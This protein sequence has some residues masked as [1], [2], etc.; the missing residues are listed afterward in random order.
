MIT[1]KKMISYGK[2]E[3]EHISKGDKLLGEFIHKTGYVKRYS[4]DDF[5]HGLCYNIINQQL[6]MKAAD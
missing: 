3:I 2:K 4:F 1:L 5:F 6:S